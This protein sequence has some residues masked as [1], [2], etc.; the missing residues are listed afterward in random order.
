MLTSDSLIVDQ[1][2]KW[3]I[4]DVLW[5]YNVR[6]RGAVLRIILAERFLSSTLIVSWGRWNAVLVEYKG[7]TRSMRIA[8]WIKI[9]TEGQLAKL[10]WLT[11]CTFQLILMEPHSLSACSSE[12]T[13]SIL[14]AACSLPESDLSR[15]CTSWFKIKSCYS[16]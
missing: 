13:F 6:K 1:C 8:L 2:D 5:E 10:S 4:V 14:F 9:I 15:F 16:R 11:F 7:V 3:R 12:R